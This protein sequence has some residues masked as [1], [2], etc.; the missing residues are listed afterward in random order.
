M[1]DEK[2]FW[3]KKLAFDKSKIVPEITVDGEIKTELE[4]EDEN[5]EPLE[6]ASVPVEWNKKQLRI[7]IKKKEN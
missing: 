7:G 6:A 1:E 2:K 5:N 4:L 3:Q